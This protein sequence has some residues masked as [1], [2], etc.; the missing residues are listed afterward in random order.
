M[1]DWIKVPARYGRSGTKVHLAHA[2]EVEGRFGRPEIRLATSMPLC[3]SYT[4]P[5]S[6]WPMQGCE[7][8]CEKCKRMEA[9]Q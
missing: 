7:I 1:N 9:E 4:R 2:A 3:G 8:T 6:G 5:G